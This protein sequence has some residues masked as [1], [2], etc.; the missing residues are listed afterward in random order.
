MGHVAFKNVVISLNRPYDFEE[1]K[2]YQSKSDC[3]VL[4]TFTKNKTKI[5]LDRYELKLDPI[6]V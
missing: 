3:L 4:T 6:W 1:C 2:N 5:K